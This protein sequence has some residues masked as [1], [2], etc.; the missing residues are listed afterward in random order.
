M[1]ATELP[2]STSVKSILFLNIK[3]QSILFKLT[4][5]NITPPILSFPVVLPWDSLFS[6][7]MKLMF[8]SSYQHTKTE[9]KYSSLEKSLAVQL[10][11]AQIV[12]ISTTGS[13]LESLFL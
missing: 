12:F 11:T 13:S 4:S 2:H 10:H 6:L 3:C 8:V 9:K 7:S 1:F 5:D